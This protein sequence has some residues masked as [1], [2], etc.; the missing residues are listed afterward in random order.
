M[1][2]K[3][4]EYQGKI[5]KGQMERIKQKLYAEG[6]SSLTFHEKI[7]YLLLH[8]GTQLNAHASAYVISDTFKNSLIDI[9][10]A[11]KRML[12][13]VGKVNEDAANFIKFLHE[14]INEYNIENSERS[15]TP[16]HAI[17]QRL[18]IR[19]ADVKTEEKVTLLLLDNNMKVLYESVI[20]VGNINTASI[21]I[22]EILKLAM[23]YEAVG[24]VLAHN[25][26]DGILAPTP[27]DI[28]TTRSISRVLMQMGIRFVNHYI[29]ADGE[30]TGIIDSINL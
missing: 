26:P 21:N 4:I 2:E 23:I 20:V 10:R 6:Y 25:H 19:Y 8:A 22:R 1:D 29:I 16:I 15:K 14:L 27:D 24:V 17:E 30:I 7:E 12:V 28:H 3:G 5:Y 13:E 11:N 9:F 18:L